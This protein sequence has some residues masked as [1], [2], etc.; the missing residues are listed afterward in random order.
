M[1]VCQVL[2]LPFHAA[3]VAHG[4]G[5][6]EAVGDCHCE[7]ELVAENGMAA[8]GEGVEQW[9]AKHRGNDLW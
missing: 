6:D 1:I 8:T 9:A 7:E 2:F 3:N 5:A 4:D